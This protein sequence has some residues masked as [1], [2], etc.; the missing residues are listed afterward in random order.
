M[1]CKFFNQPISSLNC[2]H[3]ILSHVNYTYHLI[4]RLYFTCPSVQL[5][6]NDMINQANIFLYTIVLGNNGISCPSQLGKFHCLT[7]N[8]RAMY[9]CVHTLGNNVLW[10]HG[11]VGQSKGKFGSWCDITLACCRI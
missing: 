10:L 9:K 7:G 2:G 1:L 3:S 8:L 4:N 11:G 5:I 6:S